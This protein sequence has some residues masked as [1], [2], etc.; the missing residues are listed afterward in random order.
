MSD[1][2]G[3]MR[4]PGSIAVVAGIAGVLLCAA[5]TAAAGQADHRHHR[6]AAGSRHRRLWSATSPHHW[7]PVLR[8]RSTCPSRARRSPPC[9]RPAVWSFPPFRPAASTPAETACSSAPTPTSLWS[10]SATRSPRWR[11]A[12]GGRRRLQHAA[13]LGRRRRGR[14]GLRRHPRRDR[15][16]RS[17]K[18]TAGRGRIH[19]A[20]G[21]RAAGP[22]RA[23]R[24][25]HPL[26][27]LADGPQAGRDGAR[28]PRGGGLDRGARGAGPPTS[29][30]VPG[31][32]RRLLRV[33][34]AT[35]VADI[36]VI[37]TLLVWHLIGAISSDDGYNLTIARVS[38]E[39]GYTANYYRFFGATE[40][41]FDW[42]QSRCWRSWRR[43]A[44]PG[45]GC[46]CPPP[47][48]GLR[49]G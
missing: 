30:R 44:P 13:H 21:G 29:R 5:R 16:P 27:H 32:W 43:S 4:S 10:L 11:P 40:A 39:A 22:V 8:W 24:R 47:S 41:P 12:G 49:R 45:S 48:R 38:A 2:T 36:G 1:P 20:G 37:G 9:R 33:G 14:R 23:H 26:H 6:L 7:C 46:G 25:R 34:V 15:K 18:E 19:R 28:R 35:W 3:V 17:R 31:W 42:Y